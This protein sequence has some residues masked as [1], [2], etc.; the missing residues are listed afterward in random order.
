MRLRYAGTCRVCGAAIPARTSAVYERSRRTVRCLGCPGTAI[1]PE[2]EATSSAGHDPDAHAPAPPVT[3]IDTDVE[4]DADV[5]RLRA[6]GSAVIAETLRARASGPPRSRAARFFGA[7]PLSAEALPWYQGA[8]GELEIARTLTRL[9]PGWTTIHAIPVGT[10]GSDID[11]LLVG[12]GGVFTINT[13]NHEGKRIWVGSRRLLVSGQP[14][15]HLRNASFEAKR[16]A[17]ILSR[18]AR[19]P[20][21]VTPIVAIVGA[22]AIA[23]KERPADVVVLSSTSLVRWLTRRPA[24]LTD[25]N[26]ARVSRLA[27]DPKTW[28]DPILAEADLDGFAAL[29]QEVVSA[30]RRRLVWASVGALSM[31]AVTLTLAFALAN[32]LLQATLAALLP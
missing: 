8:L 31:L 10:R 21:A 23:F 13:K 29:R 22:R 7:S 1:A 24:T 18:S 19:E 28:G 15:E 6:P 3:D 5:L 26:V 14:T 11:H 32:G 20:I 27:V 2:S 16:A 4:P 30:R 25:A 17:Q 9:G 12:P